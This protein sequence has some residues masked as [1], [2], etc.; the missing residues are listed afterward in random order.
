VPGTVAGVEGG[1]VVVA[2]E[3]VGLGLGLEEELTGA[4]GPHPARQ[5]LVIGAW[6][7]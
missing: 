2:V 1:V 6:V 5:A 3:A 4:V 7:H